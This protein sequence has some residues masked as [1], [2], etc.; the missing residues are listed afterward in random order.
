MISV[1]EILK[2]EREAQGKTLK[3]VERAIRVRE[4][5]LTL[6][7]SNDWKSFTSRVYVEGIV[8]NYAKYLK[9][10]EQKALAFFRRDYDRRD[11][12]KFK[13]RSSHR[14]LTLHRNLLKSLG[15][16]VVFL[17]FSLYFGYQV[18]LYLSPPKVQL[19]MPRTTRFEKESRIAVIG[20][21]EKEAAVTIFGERVY[22]DA[23]GVFEYQFPV[24]KGKNTLVVE[25]VGANGR[26]TIFTKDFFNE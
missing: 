14:Y 23:R 13:K 6:V 1:G 19:I 24:K 17:L 3:D 4:K 20:K 12:V 21:T 16:I 10:D 11:D 8:K 22:T 5:F 7:E 9:V 26:K 18:M 25:V 2:K 15:V